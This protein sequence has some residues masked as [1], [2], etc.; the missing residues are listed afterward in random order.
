MKWYPEFLNFTVVVDDISIDNRLI[1]SHGLSIYIDI[2]LAE[3][4]NL[5]LLFDTGSSFKILDYNAR[6]LGVRCDSLNY[7]FVSLW[8]KCHIGGLLTGLKTKENIKIVVPP[9][10]NR[11]SNE[12]LKE[13]GYILS[14]CFKH[15]LLSLLGPF[16]D[17][18]K[19]YVLLIRLRDGY[20]V[21][22]G[23]LRLGLE[24]LFTRLRENGYTKIHAIIGGLNLSILDVMT[25]EYLKTVI[26][27]FQIKII[28]PLHSTAPQARRVILKNL[29]NLDMECGVGFSATIP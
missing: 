7:I 8:R 24:K 16:G 26:E 10:F 5:C 27:E 23:C 17:R 18:I 14:S 2:P 6:I 13:K 11:D 28:Y 9:L 25:F 1:P 4:E 21:F 19:E 29:F 15:E 12:K 3:R 22:T 20:V